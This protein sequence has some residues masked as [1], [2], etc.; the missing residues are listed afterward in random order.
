MSTQ[1]PEHT[2]GISYGQELARGGTGRAFA[3]RGGLP[4]RGGPDRN[5]RDAAFGP[6]ERTGASG[7]SDLST[8]PGME[9][10]PK[11]HARTGFDLQPFAG[12]DVLL[13]DKK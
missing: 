12:L 7:C 1:K 3:K 2:H 11:R 5:C 4:W 9:S 10:D 6:L 13:K 8:R